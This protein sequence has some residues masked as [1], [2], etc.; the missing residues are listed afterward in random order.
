MAGPKRRSYIQ[1][2]P[3]RY[4]TKE[5]LLSVVSERVPSLVP[6][7]KAKTVYKC[8]CAL[9][10]EKTASMKFFKNRTESWGY[11]CLGCGKYGD[12]FQ[13]LMEV[14]G[15]TFWESFVYVKSN[16]DKFSTLTVKNKF[17]TW[18][19]L[20]I[21]FPPDKVPEEAFEADDLPF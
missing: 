15:M 19:Q 7:N 5:I 8:L 18:V 6:A 10:N 4:K 12:V 21:Q 3:G 9:H 20:K 14:A 1:L 16:A 2:D 17:S 11:K 13:F